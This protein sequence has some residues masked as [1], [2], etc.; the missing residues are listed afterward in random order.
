MNDLQIFNNSEFGSI[1]TVTIDGEPWFVG[2]DIAEALGYVKPTD[3]VRKRVDDEDRG[4]SKMETPSGKQNMTIINESGLYA[5]ILSSKLASAK[6]F[7]RWVTSEVLPTIRRTGSYNTYNL[8]DRLMKVLELIA[9]CPA[10]NLPYLMSVLN[11]S[12]VPVEKPKIDKN[13]HIPES[14][15]DFLET[16]NIINEPTADV[17]NDYCDYCYM[18]GFQPICHITFSKCVNV[19]METGT[20]VKKVNGKCVRVFF[21]KG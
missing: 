7:K 11:R 8:D 4:I 19:L 3:A 13:V 15:K 14:V 16:T 12:G 17:Y 1:R 6:R 20:T 10:E 2:K 5:L 9:N 21:I 18:N